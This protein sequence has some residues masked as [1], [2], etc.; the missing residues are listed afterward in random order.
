M[1]V[2]IFIYIYIHTYIHIHMYIICVHIYTYTYKQLYIYIYIY[3]PHLP[4]LLPLP[5]PER[6]KT[7]PACVALLPPAA[8]SETQPGTRQRDYFSRVFNGNRRAPPVGA[9]VCPGRLGYRVALGEN[10][11]KPTRLWSTCVREGWVGTEPRGTT[12]YRYYYTALSRKGK[13]DGCGFK[14][15]VREKPHL[16]C[17]LPLPWP[18]REKTPPACVALL[19]PAAS[20]ET[21]PG[22]R[23]RDY[24]SRVFNG[25]R[26]APP[27]GAVV[28][29][30][31][32]GY[33]VALG[34]NVTKPTRLWSTCV[35]QNPR[36]FEGISGWVGLGTKNEPQAAGIAPH[37]ARFESVRESARQGLWIWLR[38]GGPETASSGVHARQTLARLLNT[39]AHTAPGTNASER[40]HI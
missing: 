19:P 3:T 34:E 40:S 10:V 15:Q 36:N 22:T 6:E 28:C 29:P 18:E 38:D 23:Q 11:T 30:G 1:Y 33:R 9:V 39:A 35:L 13:R 32:L 17:L 24:F 7:P 37:L 25:N 8:S 27:V 5:W 4:C 16:P 20:S 31:R 12:E 14:V 2:Y 21:Q 26:R